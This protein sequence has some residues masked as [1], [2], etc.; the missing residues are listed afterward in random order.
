VKLLVEPAAS[1]PQL[2]KTAIRSSVL[3]GAD[4]T[5][6]DAVGRVLGHRGGGAVARADALRQTATQPT[7]LA[8]DTAPEPLT[9]RLTWLAVR[10]AVSDQN[11]QEV[12]VGR[13]SDVWRPSRRLRHRSRFEIQGT[14]LGARHIDGETV[15][16]SPERI[17]SLPTRS[18]TITVRRSHVTTSCD[19][20]PS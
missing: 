18:R 19:T 14:A 7:H 1:S 13:Q 3:L 4:R 6:R 2:A 11:V 8:V 17:D 10:G 9:A 12:L 5:S 16:T 15:V 20:F